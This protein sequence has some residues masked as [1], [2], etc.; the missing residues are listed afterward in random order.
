MTPVRTGVI[1]FGLAGRVFHAPFV[2]AVPQ[3]QLAYL[4][5]RTGQQASTAYPHATILRSVEELLASDVQLVVVATPNATHVPLAKAALEAGKHVVV[6]KPFATTSA[7]ALELEALAHERGLLLAPFHNRRFDGDFQTMQELLHAGEVGRPVVFR[8]RMDRYRPLQ[9]QNSWKEADGAVN[10]LLT[11]L[12]PHLIDQALVLFGRPES[13]A[14]SVRSDRDTSQID[15]AF[16]ILLTFHREGRQVRAELGA[17][18]LAADPQPQFLLQGTRGSYR[19]YGVDPQEPA[20]VAGARVPSLTE[21]TPWLLE[22]ESAWGTLIT[23]ADPNIPKSLERRTVPTLPGDYR[24][25]YRAVAASIQDGAPLPVT[26]RDGVR[27]A[28]L[29]ELARQ[30]SDSGRTIAIPQE[31]W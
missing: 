19:K 18:L 28:R 12:G 14:A 22:P 4:V 3:L 7:E 29:L 1:G 5:Q 26:A 8:S 10:G 2:Q 17:T 31:G 13:I 30:S 23:A 11:D 6:D 20:I 9:R 15:D 27:V 24:A 25:F 21:S 16:D